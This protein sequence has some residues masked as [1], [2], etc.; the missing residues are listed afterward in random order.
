MKSS[1]KRWLCFLTLA[2]LTFG[3]DGR[4]S[5]QTGSPATVA[6]YAVLYRKPAATAGAPAG[7]ALKPRAALSKEALRRPPGEQYQIIV[8][9][10][11][12]TKARA[13]T[14]G[15]LTLTSAVALTELEEVVTEHR[16]RFTPVQTVTDAE[17]TALEER[18]AKNTGVAQADLGGMLIV[19]PEKT[20]ADSVWHAAEA[21]HALAQT[22][23]VEVHSLDRPTPP[24][25]ADIAP[26][27]AL[28]SSY[29]TY[30]TA[31][32]INVDYAWGQFGVRGAGV[33][34]TDCEY[35]FNENH[36]DLS[37][38]VKRQANIASYYT[39]FGTDHGTAV[40]GILRAGD[41]NYGMTGTIPDADNYFYPEYSTKTNG[42]TQNRVAAIQAAIAQ[43]AP[44][45]VVILEMQ[46]TGQSSQ[47]V[48]AEYDQSV[49]TS[50][51][52]GTSAGVIVVA[53]A[54]NGSQDLDSA[55]YSSYVAWGDSGAII[56]GAGSSAR[57]RL[58]FSTYG[59]RVN[60]QG[61]GQGVATTGYADLAKYGGDDNQTYTAVFN[62]TSSAT[63]IV[64]SAVVLI[65]SAA[66]KR[67][68]RVLTPAEM[69]QL[70]IDTGLTQTGATA[71]HIGPL[72]SLSNALPA[73]LARFRPVMSTPAIFAAYYFGDANADLSGDSDG[74]GIKDLVEYFLGT[75]PTTTGSSDTARFPK[76]DNSVPGQFRYTF[77]MSQ[78]ATGV[79][80]AVEAASSLSAPNWQALQ[81]GVDGVTIT[82][83]GEDV[84]V[85]APATNGPRFF[86]LRVSR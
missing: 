22:E 59:S 49:W 16:L 63:P 17:L 13:A 65:Q 27:S 74:D 1:P 75:D 73:M 50:V 18:A 48:P 11:D 12:P 37:G 66:K 77:K 84:T 42:S 58:S 8:K 79:Q 14:T 21:L 2:L 61:W 45:D 33:R 9:F 38:L 36:E 54:G 35:A 70:L 5:A 32:G 40:S 3:A 4:S 23:F 26:P 15:Q 78:V 72:P 52:V 46:T 31:T 39:G 44:G 76:P 83:N 41:N 20:D 64:A 7:L 71:T 29:Q 24:P 28:L 68:S 62:G 55:Y 80:W 86:R 6:P 34:V 60:V 69:R 81:N 51:Q 85:V 82:T 47:Y 19:T 56:V 43:S 57:A 67:L 25:A 10:L 53:A 30:R